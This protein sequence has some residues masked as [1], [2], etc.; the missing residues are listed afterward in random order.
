MAAPKV[1]LVVAH[2]V[3]ASG[4]ETLLNLEGAFDVRRVSSIADASNAREW[5]AQVALIDGTLLSGYA[6][7]RLGTP[8]Y[9]LSGSERDGRQLA[10]KLDD[11]RGWLRKDATAAEFAAAI[12]AA[13]PGNS[14]NRS[15]LGTVGI[16]VIA[17]ACVIALALVAYLVSLAI[18]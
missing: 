4:I 3:I 9:V 10:R 12:N 11:G 6:D 15:S 1:L 14:A 17:V 7:V 8:A 5:G 18:Y 2:P 13:I 16:A